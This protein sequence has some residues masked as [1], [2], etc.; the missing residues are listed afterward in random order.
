MDSSTEAGGKRNK[1]SAFGP[2]PVQRRVKTAAHA[3]DLALVECSSGDDKDDDS[4]VQEISK[5]NTVAPPW[6]QTFDKRISKKIGGLDAKIDKVMTIAKQAKYESQMAM[7]EVSSLKNEMHQLQNDFLEMQRD[8]CRKEDLDDKIRKI[9]ADMNMG[10][11]HHRSGR[12]VFEEG[13]RELQ[14]VVGGF[15]ENTDADVVI[16]TINKFLSE[17]N[18]K[19]KIVHVGTFTD[20]CQ[21][22][23]IEFEAE[24][25]KLGFYRKILKANKRINGID[26]WFSN[27]RTFE[28][29][30]RDK[31]L[32]IIKHLLIESKGIP[33]SKVRIDWKAGFVKVSGKKVVC[34]SDEAVAEFN[35][36][37]HD[38]K[39]GVK[40]GIKAWLAKR[41]AEE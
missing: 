41:G 17:D 36:E 32:G 20:P 27:N 29:R 15:A 30:K 3:T 11:D 22:G 26:L 28:E 31:T 13:D 37:V 14:M 18:R 39:Q 7:E 23:V 38:I 35:E 40:D 19:A 9:I 16:D 24:S 12:K 21:M 6:F 4:E 8:M 33:P 5:A 34:V 10:N 25:S 2:S 1:A